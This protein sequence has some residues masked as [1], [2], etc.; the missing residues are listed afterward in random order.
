MW[1]V[2]FVSAPEVLFEFSVNLFSKLT[3]WKY[4]TIVNYN[5]FQEGHQPVKIVSAKNVAFH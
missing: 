3:S 4:M 1:E 5:L 2:L